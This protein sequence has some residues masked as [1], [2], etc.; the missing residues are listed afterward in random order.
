M[1]TNSA[2]R[3]FNLIMLQKKHA[4]PELLVGYDNANSDL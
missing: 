4:C 2:A 3:S 1:K